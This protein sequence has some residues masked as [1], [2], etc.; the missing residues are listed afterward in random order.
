MSKQDVFPEST[1]CGAAPNAHLSHPDQKSENYSLKSE[2]ELLQSE[3]DV[4][5]SELNQAL[6]KI[7]S[8]ESQHKKLNKRLDYMEEMIRAALA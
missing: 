4:L 7:K 8:L 1:A 2:V 6:T 5:T 3:R